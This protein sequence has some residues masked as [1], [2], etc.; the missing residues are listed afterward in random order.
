MK[1]SYRY[2]YINMFYISVSYIFRYQII[3]SVNKQIN[4]FV[5]WNIL[6]SYYQYHEDNFKI[7]KIIFELETIVDKPKVQYTISKI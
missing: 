1:L 2:D 5:Y 3:I 7:I 4:L 6:T